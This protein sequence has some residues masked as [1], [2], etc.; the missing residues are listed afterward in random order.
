MEDNSNEQDREQGDHSQVPVSRR[1]F[2]VGVAAAGAAATAARTLPGRLGM[3]D[4]G[5]GRAAAST[6]GSFSLVTA[7]VSGGELLDAAF[8]SADE[9]W[10]VGDVGLALH[11]NQT[12][13]LRF[14]GS[15]WSVVVSPNEGTANNGLNGVSM[16]PGAGWA[17]GYTQI[18]GPY[19]PLAMSWDGKKWSLN[20]PPNLPSDSLFTAVD[21]LADGSAWAV[22]FQTTTAGTRLT[23]IEHAS[24]GAWAPVASPNVKASALNSLMAVSGTQATG[25]WAVGFW[26]SPTGLQ[27]LVLRYDTTKPSPSWVSVSGVPAPGKIDTVLT[28][29]DVR[30]ASDVWAVGYY[31]DGSADRPLA[32]HWDGSTW[33]RSPVPGTGVLRDVQALASGKVWAAG[34]YYNVSAQRYQTL[35]VH[36]NGTA[37]TTVVSADSGSADDQLIGLAANPTGSMITLAGRGAPTRSSNR[38]AVPRDRYRSPAGHRRR[39]RRYRPLRASAQ[40]PA[41]RQRH[42]RRRPRSR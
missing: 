9:W 18:N 34:S 35:V 37:W 8:V 30:T 21:T 14:D 39:C 24:G 6:C 12:L 10:A 25:L 1:S 40:T 29:V 22:G 17:V 7:P 42:P 19:Q 26:L 2:V 23:L 33:A 38:R 13:I 16:I 11:P 27:P 36:F 4:A 28:G 15:K 31:N 5:T 32:L 41:H 20:S 3:R